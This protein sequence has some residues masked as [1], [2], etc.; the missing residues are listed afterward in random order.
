V[1]CQRSTAPSDV[2][3]RKPEVQVETARLH[4]PAVVRQLPKN[5]VVGWLHPLD[6]PIHTLSVDDRPEI[7]PVLAGETL[8]LVSVD[9]DSNIKN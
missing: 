6:L 4:P 7:V 9:S 1:V 2:L 3:T 5:P 8:I